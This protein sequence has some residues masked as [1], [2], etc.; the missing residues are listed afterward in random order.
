M[1]RPVATT[2]FRD[3]YDEQRLGVLERYKRYNRS[4]GNSLSTGCA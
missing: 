1:I 4:K 3:C 2:F